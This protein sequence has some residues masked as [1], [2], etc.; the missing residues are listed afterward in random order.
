M[1]SR[2]LIAMLICLVALF[3]GVLPQAEA[4]NNVI[5]ME[6]FNRW[7]FSRLQNEQAARKT[8]LSRIEHEIERINLV[9]VLSEDEKAKIRLAGRGDVKRF[10]DDVREA[11]RK[12]TELG[13]VNQNQVQEAYQLASPLAQRINSGLFDK[14]SL[15]KKVAA[16]APSPERSARIRERNQR[17]REMQK[18]VAIKAYVATMGRT[19]P[20]TSK[21]RGQLIDLISNEV[22]LAHF[23]AT[24]LFQLISY[25]I[26]QLPEADLRAIFDEKQW[27]AFENT[28]AQAKAMKAMLKQ[29]GLIDDE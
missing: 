26:S 2:L 14:N 3:H 5:G 19:I 11:R 23:N 6:Q 18:K 1:T 29:Q 10:F 28:I 12:F 22:D 4:Q 24:Y 21:Q 16:T 13:E 7:I 25:R 20:L 17:R 8:L 27:N 9:A 15:L